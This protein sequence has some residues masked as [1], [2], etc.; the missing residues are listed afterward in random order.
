MTIDVS[1]VRNDADVVLDGR[2][3]CI[4]DDDDLCRGRIAILLA[5][6]GVRVFEADDTTSLQKILDRAMLDCILLDYDLVSENGLFAV[7]RLKQRYPDLA[8]IVMVSA[9]ETQR[10]AIRAFRAGIADYIG[11]RHLT[12]DEL[13]MA[14]RRAIGLRIRDEARF[15]ELERLRRN[16]TLDERTGLLTRHALEERMAMID[17]VARRERHNYG[18]VGLR[19]ARIDAVLERFGVAAT[20]RILRAFGNKLRDQIRSTDLCG[21]WA[22][23]TFVYLV[24]AI[25]SPLSFASIAKRIGAQ[26]DLEIDLASAHLSV[27][28]ISATVFH[29]DDAASLADM[30]AVLERRL[31]AA[32]VAF[33]ESAEG[34]SEW[35]RQ[36]ETAN[37]STTDEHT[38]RR[39]EKR[40]RTLKQGR[41]YLDGLQ[42]TLDCTVRNLSPGGAGLRLMGPTAVP[43]FF[44]LKISDSGVVRK[45]RK[46]WHK[47]NDLG[48]E[49]LP[50]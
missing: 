5:Q 25:S 45:V 23:G 21:A 10:T 11:K 39:R 47:N 49:F 1:E 33:G 19:V 17:E 34:K 37:P 38:E 13:T 30:I 44:R 14:L 41:I 9:D 28:V 6:K 48:V 42:S 2:R 16:A 46:C 24:D 27:P 12:G 32:T 18:L 15:V 4:V 7:E 36:A 50:D 26:A 29:P 31:E 8:P 22:R 3:V 43:E 20:D 35:V 40:L